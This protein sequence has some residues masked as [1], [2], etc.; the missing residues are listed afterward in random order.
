ML[1]L[2]SRRAARILLV[3]GR[4]TRSVPRSIPRAS[5]APTGS[6]TFLSLFK[7]KPRAANEPSTERAPLLSQ[8]NLFHEFSKSPIPDIRARASAI[9]QLAPCPV[10]VDE[11]HGV[12]THEDAKNEPKAVAFDCPDCG[13]PTHCSEDHWKADKEHAKYCGRLREVNEDEHDLWS[14]RK[15]TEF[16][17]P[18]PHDFDAALSF[19]NWDVFWY[20]REF[21]SLNTDRSRR[22]TSKILTYPITIGSVL[23]QY[24]Y[25]TTSNQRLTREGSRSLAALRTNLHVPLGTPETPKAA[26]TKPQMRIFILGARAESSLPPHVWEQLTMLFPSAMFHIYFIGPQVS[27]PRPASEVYKPSSKPTTSSEQPAPAAK[28]YSS[29]TTQASSENTGGLTDPEPSYLPNVYEPP[30]PAPIPY[31]KRTRDSIQRYGVPSYTVPYTAAL[32][33]TGMRANYSEVHPQFAETFDPYTDCFFMFSP[34]LGFPSQTS[35]DPETG[36]PYLQVASPTE[37]GPVMPQLLATKCPIFI[38]VLSTAP[39]VAGEFDWIVTPG[40]NAFQS[41]K[42]EVAD[43]DPRVMVRTNWGVWGIRGK[44]RDV[45]E[46]RGWLGL[47]LGAPE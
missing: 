22:H 41:E 19:S 4:P 46:H 42:W 27:L 10:C 5:L 29:E 38:T 39:G 13:W 18:G 8:D 17:M 6:R 1:S 31:L 33:I 9:R 37:W 20:T 28:E 26:E 2:A 12:H 14:G 7:K 32:T 15:M 23:H 34:G 16:D 40:P 36:K 25:L 24:S 45:Q 35:M 21:P 11:D 44:R 3:H 43:F 30:T 47:S